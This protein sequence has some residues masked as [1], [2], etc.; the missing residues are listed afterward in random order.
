MNT[1]RKS[2]RGN[3]KTMKKSIWAVAC[4]FFLSMT[5]GAAW[6]TKR[7][8][9]SGAK[10][11]RPSVAARDANVYAVWYDS[12]AGVAEIYFRRSLDKGLTWLAAKKIS[13]STENSY[14]PKIAVSDTNV[15]VVWYEYVG[16]NAEI[17]FRRSTDGGVTWQAVKKLTNNAGVSYNPMVAIS[18]GTVYV[19]WTDSAPGNAEIYFRK[20]TDGGASWLSSMNLTND[21]AD[22]QYPSISVYG[23][24]VYVVWQSTPP[25]E[26]AEIYFGRS[27]DA[28]AIWQTKKRRT[29][30]MGSSCE[31]SIAVNGANIHVV[32]WDLTPGHMEV[33]FRR[34]MD[35]GATW[36]SL[37]R[38]T[39]NTFSSGHPSLAVDT[40]NIHV[41]YEDY[42]DSLAEVALM[43]SGDSGA[44]WNASQKITDNAGGSLW[45][46]IAVGGAKKYVVW[47]DYTSG[48]AIIY[49][50]FSPL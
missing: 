12:Q 31:P 13:S 21:S 46:K 28:G 50:K 2:G 23:P 8:S 27:W 7:I 29:N 33:Y 10:P 24:N 42:S 16:P 44:T 35:G 48:S 6:T 25:G 4:L 41:V 47:V 17:Y 15:C 45:P 32:W 5:L 26:D 39:N 38:L 3:V 37:K 20:S 49:I 22:S 11:N 1:T 9:G 43:K 14:N 40:S 30:N 34:S 19:V 18:A 36:P